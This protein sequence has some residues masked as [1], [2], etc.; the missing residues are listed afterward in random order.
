[1][2]PSKKKMKHKRYI[3]NKVPWYTCNKCGEPK[4]PHR[5]CSTNKEICALRS[6]EWEVKLS[7][8]GV[9]ERVQNGSM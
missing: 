2:S 5:I 9:H 1:M 7:G 3:P 8:G 6:D 4:R